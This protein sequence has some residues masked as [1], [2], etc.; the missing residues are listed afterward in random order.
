VKGEIWLA[1]SNAPLT[2]GSHV[3]V[4]GRD[5]LVLRLSGTE[6]GVEVKRDPPGRGAPTVTLRVFFIASATNKRSRM[7]C[8]NGLPASFQSHQH[9]QAEADFPPP[10]GTIFIHNINDLFFRVFRGP[11]IYPQVGFLAGGDSS[12]TT[13]SS[14][15]VARSFAHSSSVRG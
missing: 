5:G 8:A 13:F 6:V 14:M 11:Q 4:V 9:L 2:A 15:I 10:N 1:R 7:K 12:S 3:K